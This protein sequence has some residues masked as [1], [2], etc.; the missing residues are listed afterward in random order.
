MTIKYLHTGIFCCGEG[1]GGGGGGEGMFQKVLYGLGGEDLLAAPKVHLTPLYTIFDRNG[2]SFVNYTSFYR[3]WYPFP[4]TVETL[5][6]FV[7]SVL[8]FLK[9]PFTYLTDSFPYPFLYFGL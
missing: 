3:K 9:C 2:N 6:F 1:V 5:S 4:H 8:D 7:G